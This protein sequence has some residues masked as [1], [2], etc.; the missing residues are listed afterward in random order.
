[1]YSKS[2]AVFF[3]K[4]FVADKDYNGNFPHNFVMLNSYKHIF[5]LSTEKV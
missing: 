5:V 1:M 3:H 2:Y 4:I